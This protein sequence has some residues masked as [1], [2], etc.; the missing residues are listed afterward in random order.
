MENLSKPLVGSLIASAIVSYALKGTISGGGPQNYNEQEAKKETGW[1]PYSIKVGDT[2]ISYQRV[3]PLSSILGMA[4]DMAEAGKYGDTETIGKWGARLTG[5]VLENLTSKTFL[6]GLEGLFT[7][8]H[9][10]KQYAER[11]IKQM[12]ASLVP[13]IIGKAAQAID[14]TVRKTDMSTAIQARIPATPLWGASKNLE[15]RHTPTGAELKRPGS[16]L[17]RFASPF[18]RSEEKHTPEAAVANEMER[19]GFA[20]GQV[21]DYMSP[22]GKKVYLTGEERQTLLDARLKATKALVRVIND[23][24]YQRLPDT[25]DEAPYG[26]R[27][28]ETTLRRVY[29]RYMNQARDRIRGKVI[30]RAREGESSVN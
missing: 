17:E 27:T 15:A 13:N 21:Q 4:A 14:D 16:A 3:E 1:L 19:V 23:P 9:D 18:L 30:R 26:A 28:K 5:S 20:P 24:S 12:E 7:A 6:A 8:L 2:W 29:E 22:K 25:V 10:P 11:Y